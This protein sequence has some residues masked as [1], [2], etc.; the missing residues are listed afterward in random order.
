MM[1]PLLT[2][3]ALNSLFFGIYGNTMRAL[4]E[5]RQVQKTLQQ[6][7]DYEELKSN[8]GFRSHLYGV[9]SR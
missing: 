7:V 6:I 8:Q 9:P 4:Q 5:L 1:F 3:G 2:A